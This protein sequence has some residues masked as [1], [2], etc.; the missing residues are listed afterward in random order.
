MVVEI[1]EEL[2]ERFDVEKTG[3][4][5]STRW[6]GEERVLREYLDRGFGNGYDFDQTG[7]LEGVF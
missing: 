4:G 7:R 6:V 5:V 3:L 1:S 2:K